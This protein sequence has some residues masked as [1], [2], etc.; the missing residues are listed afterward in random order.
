MKLIAIFTHPILVVSLFCLALVSGDHFGGFYL[1][2]ILMA[3]P[4]GGIHALIALAGIGLILFNYVRFKRQSKFLID[5]L[6]NIVGVALLYL[7]MVL[8]FRNSWNYN[9]QTFGQMLPTIS[10]VVFGLVSLGFLV[11]SVVRLAHP[12]SN[13]P[14]PAY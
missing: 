1:L 13:N 4:H 8:F 11:H 14:N 10:Y 3:L 12:R 2:Y 6:L 5:P 9:G 7:S